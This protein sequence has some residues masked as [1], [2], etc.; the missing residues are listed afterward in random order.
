MVRLLTDVKSKLA[1]ATTEEIRSFAKA[2]EASKSATATDVS[3][4][5]VTHPHEPDSLITTTYGNSATK[6][7]IYKVCPSV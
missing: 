6:E 7:C 1:G 5:F 4:M 2:L 3:T